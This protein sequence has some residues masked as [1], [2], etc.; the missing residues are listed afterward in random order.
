MADMTLQ[1]SRLLEQSEIRVGDSQLSL[2]ETLDIVSIAESGPATNTDGVESESGTSSEHWQ[3][4][5]G[6]S[7]PP[8]GRLIHASGELV[9]LGLQPALWFAI[10][11]RENA[12]NTL[13]SQ[14]QT[15]TQAQAEAEAEAK[16]KA[17]AEDSSPATDGTCLYR[18][19][20]SI[21]HDRT[22]L[23]EQ[24]DAWAV[25]DLR[26]TL[27][28]PA[29]ERV[30]SLD[31][32][33]DRFSRELVARTRMEHLSVIIHRLPTNGFRLYSARSTAG[34]FWHMLQTSLFNVA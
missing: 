24:S 13:A 27:A 4:T 34:D 10:E 11:P 33:A 26:G 20:Q 31:L 1:A 17:K 15:Q 2:V 29:L 19:L 16:A 12:G 8:V 18:K 5:I 30:C 6:A 14:T 9:L 7:L 3:M 23:T 21:R 32:D 22:Y 28:L 25:L